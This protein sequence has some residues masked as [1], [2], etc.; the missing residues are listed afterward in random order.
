LFRTFL[1]GG[2]SSALSSPVPLRLT[3][4]LAFVAAAKNPALSAFLLLGYT[5]FDAVAVGGSTGGKSLSESST[6]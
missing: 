2:S 5:L 6:G 3:S 4:I 1:L